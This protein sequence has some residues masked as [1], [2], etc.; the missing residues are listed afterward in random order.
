MSYEVQAF[1]FSCRQEARRLITGLCGI[2]AE[3]TRVFYIDRKK[4]LV[5]AEDRIRGA[6]IYIEV[7]D[8]G[9]RRRPLRFGWSIFADAFGRYTRRKAD[10]AIRDSLGSPDVKPWLFGVED[11]C[12]T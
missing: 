10:V 11:A 3:P 12:N 8:W 7:C 2:P 1:G 4:N 5:V 6:R 9:G